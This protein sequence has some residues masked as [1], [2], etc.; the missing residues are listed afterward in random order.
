M[1]DH[2]IRFD[3]GHFGLEFATSV[4]L[5]GTASVSHRGYYEIRFKSLC[6]NAHL[7]PGWHPTTNPQ[8]CIICRKDHNFEHVA[9][10]MSRRDGEKGLSKILESLCDPLTAMVLGGLLFDR[11]DEAVVAL[12]G[13]S[14]GDESLSEIA[15]LLSRE[16]AAPRHEI[17]H[18]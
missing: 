7:E 2:W 4:G 18:G 12:N 8:F 11:L 5:N 6:C 16:L 14:G 17:S 3:V 13:G 10:I 15:E 9:S 1:S